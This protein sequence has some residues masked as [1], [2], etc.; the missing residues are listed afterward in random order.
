MSPGRNQVLT[1]FFCLFFSWLL[2]TE[3]WFPYSNVLS[4]W[5]MVLWFFFS[6]MVPN[7]L[8]TTLILTVLPG[9]SWKSKYRHSYHLLV[10]TKGS[11]NKW[12]IP[13]PLRI[14]IGGLGLNVPSILGAWGA[15]LYR[16]MH[17]I[18]WTPQCSVFS[19]KELS[20]Q[21]SHRIWDFSRGESTAYFKIVYFLP[22]N[23][24]LL[25]K[26]WKFFRMSS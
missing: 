21:L 14:L 23:V 1:T 19:V 8:L 9:G 22:V 20:C 3:V 4:F 17:S 15:A 26:S 11:D 2:F 6:S 7:E 5:C 24:L 25:E 12:L 10:E 16:V 13:E 18:R